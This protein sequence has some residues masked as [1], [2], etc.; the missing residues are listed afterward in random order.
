[1]IRI[2]RLT[3]YSIILM[4]HIAHEPP[5]KSFTARDLSEA[6]DLPRPTVSKVLKMLAKAK[7]LNSRRGVGGGYQLG[8]DARE[9]SVAEIVSALEGPVML[10][11]CGGSEEAGSC[12]L[13]ANCQVR[14]A[15][16]WI[17]SKVM[18]TLEGVSLAEMSELTRS[19]P[20]CSSSVLERQ[21]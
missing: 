16:H 1:V 10:T 20:G 12:N 13:A 7:L 18:E 21:V 17:N 8:R 11:Q 19:S 4:N 3:D 6:L 5:K 15:W 14:N 9:I 2:A